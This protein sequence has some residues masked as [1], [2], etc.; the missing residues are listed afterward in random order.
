MSERKLTTTKD[1]TDLKDP[2]SAI[3]FE[4][5]A[6]ELQE[7]LLFPSKRS[8]IY[9]CQRWNNFKRITNKIFEP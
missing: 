8:N 2:T 9:L 1:P 3:S 4:E 6:A 5:N 7:F